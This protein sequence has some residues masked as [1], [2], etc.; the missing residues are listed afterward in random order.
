MSYRGLGELDLSAHRAW[1][2][3]AAN[4]L[5]QA[6]STEG[7]RFLTRSAERF[8]GK[9][10]PGLQVAIPGGPASA[11]LSHPQPFTI[12]D[13]HVSGLLGERVGYLVPSQ[14]ILLALPLSELDDLK[15]AKQASA[16]TLVGEQLLSSPVTWTHGFPVEAPAPML[17]HP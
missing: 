4:L 9:G 16:R 17:T 2:T 15:W 13:R 7:V 11:W 12:L 8:L 5:A 6:H 1:D 3:A 10:A 14:T